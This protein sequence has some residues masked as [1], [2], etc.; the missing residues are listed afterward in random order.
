MQ[1]KVNTKLP[2][3][4]GL[5]HFVGIGGIGMSGIA[6]LL[7]NLGYQVSGSDIKNTQ[8]V[9][10]LRNLGIP[11]KL[12]HSAENLS[13]VEI[14]VISSAISEDN[15]EIIE[16]RRRSIPLVRRSEM[17]A[18]LMRLKS[19]IAI[20]GTHGKTTTTSMIA[21]VLEAGQLDPTVVNGGI[22][23]AYGS[24]ARLGTGDWMVVEADESD[25]TLVKIPSTIALVTN[26]DPEHLDYYGSFR[27]LKKT[28]LEFLGNIPFYGVGICCLDHPVVCGLI[29]KIKDRRI[30]TYGFNPRADFVIQNLIYWEKKAHFSI[31]NKLKGLETKLELPMYGDHNVSNAAAAVSVAF[32]LD[33]PSTAIVH[34]LRNFKGVK[35]RFTKVATWNGVD[36]IDDYAHHPVEIKAVLSAARQYSAG[37]VIAVHQ[38]HRYSR[39]DSLMDDFCECFEEADIIGITPVYAAGELPQKGVS[40]D[41]LIS[42]LNSDT[43]RATA[44]EDEISLKNFLWC[45]GKP[46]DIFVCLGAGTITQWVNKLPDLLEVKN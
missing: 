32:H 23:Q 35:R 21:A 16:A 13:S 9:E 28:F 41:I 19:N 40:S 25:G 22:I 38:P 12:G 26:L 46:G 43:D 34:A 11:I 17:L 18:E 5:I 39:L 15:V 6:E 24:N 44:I 45:Q 37:R 29:S 42:R 7:L 10:R 1:G 31:L 20:A 3:N 14:V 8:I 30:L 33:V 36:I 2:L 27:K 4:L